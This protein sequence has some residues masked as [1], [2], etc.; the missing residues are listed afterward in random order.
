MEGWYDETENIPNSFSLSTWD[1][2]WFLA[3][4]H[5]LKGQNIFSCQ[6]LNPQIAGSCN[7]GQEQMNG[8]KNS[9][10]KNS[11]QCFQIDI[12]SF[13]HKKFLS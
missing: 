8:K 1:V 3:Q 6:L 4:H 10:Q 5:S 7:V 13:W 2:T 9:K 12:F 11:C